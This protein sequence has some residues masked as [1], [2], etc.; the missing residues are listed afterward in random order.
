[1]PN[2]I[3]NFLHFITSSELTLPVMLMR[4][5]CSVLA[6]F[7]LGLERKLHLQN[8]VLRTHVLISG[9]SCML[10]II[11]IYVPQTYATGDPSRI[12]AQIVSGIG[13]LGGGAILRQGLNIK[14]LNTAAT[15]W[16]AAAIGMAT[17][18]GLIPLAVVALIICLIIM[19]LLV[20]F[21]QRYFPA[22]QVKHL[23]L[24]FKNSRIDLIKLKNELGSRGII[25][26]NTDF[27]EEIDADRFHITFT[28]K[29]PNN[30]NTLDLT[31]NLKSIGKLLKIQMKD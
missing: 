31:D 27:S 6:G 22:E 12:A 14:G 20:K 25:I 9:S 26:T 17:G 8:G 30:I 4:L 28:V 10:M 19:F 11:S 29:V 3:T 2:F 24:V 13:F 21:E 5:V 1:M 23:E 7:F 16:V 18:A 15:I